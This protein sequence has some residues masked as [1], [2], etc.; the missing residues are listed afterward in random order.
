MGG[1]VIIKKTRNAALEA[2]H[3]L[4]KG[5]DYPEDALFD[6]PSIHILGREALSIEGCR[7]VLLCAEDRIVLDMGGFTATIYGS[8]LT[9]DELSVARLEITADITALALDLKGEGE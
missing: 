9:I 5:V 7:G 6:S 4:A 2:A 3:R 1:G 8:S